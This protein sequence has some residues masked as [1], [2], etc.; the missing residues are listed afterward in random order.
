MTKA[1]DSINRAALDAAQAQQLYDMARANQAE[2]SLNLQGL[3]MTPERYA[4]LQHALDVRFHNA[5]IDYT[6][7]LKSDLSPGEI[8]AASIVA[9]DTKST[10]QAIVDEAQTTHRS[11][12]EVAN[13][14]GMQAL[15]LAIFM[16]LILLDYVDDPEKEARVLT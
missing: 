5:T 9:A 7:M 3:A 1:V 16:N 12:I 2:A 4:T 14:H 11:V 8:A 6:T 10:P 15:A 13:Q